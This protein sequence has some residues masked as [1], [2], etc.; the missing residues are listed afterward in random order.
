MHGW[1]EFDRA[2]GSGTGSGSGSGSAA[3][4]ASAASFRSHTFVNRNMG[5][6]EARFE[7]R[8][9][10]T[11]QRQGIGSL[12]SKAVP[13]YEASAAH[14]RDVLECQYVGSGTDVVANPRKT[15]RITLEEHQRAH[16]IYMLQRPADL[17]LPGDQ[18]LCNDIDKCVID[19]LELI[20]SGKSCAMRL[21]CSSIQR[22]G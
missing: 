20:E 13:L 15:Q 8:I 18:Q 17:L 1:D 10:T 14:F 9:S 4:P 2:H 19:I 16:T 12:I 21:T 3:G 22:A 11:T 7:E 5:R 6:N